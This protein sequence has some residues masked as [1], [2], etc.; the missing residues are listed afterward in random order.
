MN[1]VMCGCEM[2]CTKLVCVCVCVYMMCMIFGNVVEDSACV[3][4]LAS[5]AGPGAGHGTDV[6]GY[7]A[8]L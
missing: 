7:T 1:C 4:I 5:R 6:L 2:V 8:N 3:G